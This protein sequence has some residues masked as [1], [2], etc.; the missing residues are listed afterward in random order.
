MTL[1]GALGP[2]V[3]SGELGKGETVQLAN[4]WDAE[5]LDGFKHRNIRLA[6]VHG[7]VTEIGSVY[8]HDIVAVRRNELWHPVLH[9]DAQHRLRKQ[10]QG[11]LGG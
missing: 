2:A 7:V 3:P 4:G 8:V 6:R 1:Y 5:L 11:L 9:S 10:V